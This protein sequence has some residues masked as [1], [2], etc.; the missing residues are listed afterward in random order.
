MRR[1]RI[2]TKKAERIFQLGR[3]SSS[4]DFNKPNLGTMIVL[5]IFFFFY[6][7]L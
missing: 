6:I 1:I 2:I 4:A 7:I 5:Y 3:H